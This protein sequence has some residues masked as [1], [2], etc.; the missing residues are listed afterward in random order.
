MIHY[1]KGNLLDSNCDY[2][3]HQVNCQGVMG[4]G[5]ARQIRERWPRVYTGYVRFCEREEKG[6]SESL[7]GRVF[8]TNGTFTQEEHSGKT[9]ANMFSQSNYGYDGA[10]YTSYSAFR[11]CLIV[12][13]NRVPTNKT[14]GFPKNIGCGLGG[15]NWNIVR[16]LIEE[17]LGKDYEVYIYEYE[18][19]D[20]R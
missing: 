3:C 2:I 10:R 15:G 18:P 20:A 17:I 6:D 8:F 9:V 16:A 13:R 4:S 1:V 11:D 5:I 19:E 7:L 12:I 14:I